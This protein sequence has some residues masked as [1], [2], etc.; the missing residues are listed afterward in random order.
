MLLF[1]VLTTLILGWKSSHP[2]F[3]VHVL[4]GG[5]PGPPVTGGGPFLPPPTRA[6]TVL[7]LLAADRG[8]EPLSFG[9]PS[10]PH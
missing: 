6:P 8:E 1:A 2:S 3:L 5:D 7:K 9:G 10:Q 4:M